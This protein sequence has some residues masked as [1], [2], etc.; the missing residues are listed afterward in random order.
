MTNKEFGEFNVVLLGIVFDT[1]K[2]KIL[3]GKRDEDPHISKLKWCFPGGRLEEGGNVEETLKK[4][5][6]EKTGLDV[7]NLG[8]IYSRV[9]PEKDDLLLI[10]FLC[11]VTGG[12][13]KAGDD[14]KELKWVSPEEVESHFTTS[15]HPHVKEYVLNLK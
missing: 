2:R 12:K 3:I 9:P 1:K 4:R 5:I 13:E 11:E 7:E 6:K 14:L 10:Y 15:F 8:S